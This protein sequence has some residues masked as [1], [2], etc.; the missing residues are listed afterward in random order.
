MSCLSGST[1]MS[2]T[3]TVIP[4]LDENLNPKSF[5]LSSI[6]EV[7]V[8]LNLLNTS[9]MIFPKNFLLKGSISSALSKYSFSPPSPNCVGSTKYLSGVVLSRLA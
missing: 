5:I 6:I 3:P 7:S 9:A 4:A 1:T 8:M 2:E